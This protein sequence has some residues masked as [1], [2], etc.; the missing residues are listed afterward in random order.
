MVEFFGNL[1]ILNNNN[2]YKVDI[3]YVLYNNKAHI[4]SKEFGYNKKN[5]NSWAI[6]ISYQYIPTK[7][8]PYSF[9]IKT[10]NGSF[11]RLP[12]DENCMFYICIFDYIFVTM[13]YHKTTINK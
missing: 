6:Y 10:Q 1:D 11:F 2:S 3:V 13:L 9:L 4:M 5:N 12:Q 8:Q 7:C